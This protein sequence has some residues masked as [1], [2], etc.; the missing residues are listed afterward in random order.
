MIE[1]YPSQP[2]NSDRSNNSAPPSFQN[3][4]NQLVP[5]AEEEEEDWSV[6]KFWVFYGVER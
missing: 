3:Q 1:N 6:Q 5:W 4:Q 2:S